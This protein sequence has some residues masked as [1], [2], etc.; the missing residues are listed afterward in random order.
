MKNSDISL[1]ISWSLGYH[2]DIQRKTLYN[3]ALSKNLLGSHTILMPFQGLAIRIISSRDIMGISRD[4]HWDI[5][6]IYPL[7]ISHGCSGWAVTCDSENLSLVTPV[8][9]HSKNRSLATRAPFRSK[10]GN[11]GNMTCVPT[12]DPN[13]RWICE[14]TRHAGNPDNFA[15]TLRNLTSSPK[16]SE[17]HWLVVYLPL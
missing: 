11:G 8:T 10:Q 13:F 17:N 1:A 2:G 16:I 4:N 3:D 15:A 7:V 9:C 12:F 5:M 14:Y 6:G